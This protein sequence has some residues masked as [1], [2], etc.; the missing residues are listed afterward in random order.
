[1]SVKPILADNITAQ[2]GFFT[3]QGGASEGVFA[4]LNTGYASGDSIDKVTAN[5]T[6][7]A[8]FFGQ[9]H[10][11]LCSLKQVHSADCVIITQPFDVSERPEADA[12]ATRTPHIILGVLTADCAPVLFHDAK[13]HVI[14]ASHA[15]WKGAVYGVLE[16]TVDA[17]IELG[18]DLHHIQAAIGPTIA[19]KNYE[20]DSVFYDNVLQQHDNAAKHFIPSPL[21]Q[22]THYLFNLPAFIA[23]RLS[24]YGIK[25]VSLPSHDTYADEVLFY[26]YRRTTHR[27]EHQFGRQL[28]AIMLANRE[29]SC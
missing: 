21:R 13:N 2:H 7:I 24:V 28:S 12:L 9:P 15:G 14:G 16:R 26:S 29:P 27:N 25:D 19:Q 6:K 22:H 3:R 4:S 20:V 10:A 23:E 11:Q 17:M 5:R 8:A 1:M 18:A